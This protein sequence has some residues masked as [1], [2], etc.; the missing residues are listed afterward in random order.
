MSHKNQVDRLCL[1][2]LI[3]LLVAAVIGVSSRLAGA[4]GWFN[5]THRSLL[6]HFLAGSACPILFTLLLGTVF[7]FGTI[8]V[9]WIKKI[10]GITSQMPP[11]KSDCLLL[12][13]SGLSY[14]AL[15]LTWETLQYIERQYQWFQLDQFGCDIAGALVWFAVVLSYSSLANN[16]TASTNPNSAG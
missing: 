12:A 6:E 10:K 1:A 3:W 4:L 11:F 16:C 8:D 9:A 7:F 14:I 5:W 13:L 15:S 2:P